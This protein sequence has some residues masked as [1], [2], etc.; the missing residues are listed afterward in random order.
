[1][2]AEIAWVLIV[3]PGTQ[4]QSQVIHDLDYLP[5][6]LSVSYDYGC[7]APA[8]KNQANTKYNISKH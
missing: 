5:D 2:Y 7:R 8:C 1:M 6:Y 4:V 3:S